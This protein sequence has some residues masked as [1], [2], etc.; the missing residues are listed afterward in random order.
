MKQLLIR[1]LKIYFKNKSGVF[2]SLL[3]VIVIFALFVL[4]I[5][6]AVKDRLH[7]IGNVDTNN[8]LNYW[9]LSGMLSSV[10]LTSC[11][12]AYAVMVSDKENK[13]LKDL[14]VAPVSKSVIMTSYLLTGIIVSVIMS[15]CVLVF[16]QSYVLIKGGSLINWQNGLLVVAVIL[17]TC[18]MSNA[19]V[20]FVI[21][22]IKNNNAFT[23]ISII[24]GT[25]VGFLVGAYVSI[26][27]LPSAVQWVIKAFPNA[28]SAGLFRQYFMTKE[29][30][31]IQANLIVIDNLNNSIKALN[32]SASLSQSQLMILNSSLDSAID[33]SKNIKLADNSNAEIASKLTE[34]KTIL[35][36]GN[37]DDAY[38]KDTAT[39]LA[40][41]DKYL[42]SA[43]FEAWRTN[44][45]VNIGMVYQYGDYKLNSY[46]YYLIITTVGLV[47]YVLSSLII[48]KKPKSMR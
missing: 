3:G 23:T 26:G 19:I 45:E 46:W 43:W 27:T 9:M 25:L 31:N 42:G 38:L 35:N 40:S 15:L 28:Y 36:S 14:Y 47:F 5:G 7:V 48:V 11:L 30:D 13:Q 29:L 39:Y 17:L 16:G 10:P 20:C 18:F 37:Y 24:I 34:I 32:D 4:F 21:L 8:L 44:F 22:F 12:G 2:F 6:N 33:L 1:N 41:V